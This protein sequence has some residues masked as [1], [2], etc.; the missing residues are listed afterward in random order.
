MLI[1]TICKKL[2]YFTGTL[3]HQIPLP[4]SSQGRKRVASSLH[5]DWDLFKEGLYNTSGGCTIFQKKKK[6][7]R[8][9]P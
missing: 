5:Q 1:N 8:I 2:N 9:L 4:F 3:V 6:Y 7:L